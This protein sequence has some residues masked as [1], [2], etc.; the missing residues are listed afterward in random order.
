MSEGVRARRRDDVTRQVLE[1]GRRHLTQYGAAALSLRA[2]T[3]DLGMV[4]SAVYRYVGSRDELLTLLVVDA[5]TEL[6]DAVDARL[7]DA[8]RAAWD[9]RI[10]AVCNAV[11]DWALGEPARYALLYG[12]P[13]PGYEAPGEQTMEPGTRVILALLRLVAEGVTAGDVTDGPA[14]VPV[15]WPLRAD[16]A[17]VA[18]DVGMD[19][20]PAVMARAVLLWATLFGA[21]S[22]EVFGQ[23]GEDTFK[24]RGL[25]F[26][27]QI[28]LAL[29]VVRG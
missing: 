19:V 12:S 2:V 29:T 4:S 6:G 16:L 21:V 9:T 1:I 8:A 14:L 3:R 26:E 17:R 28:R 23:Y 5:Y 10:L 25:L 22:L 27:Q 24:E 20:D 15:P 11:R 18:A 7:A 13:V